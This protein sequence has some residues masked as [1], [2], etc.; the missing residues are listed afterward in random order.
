M[1]LLQA[2]HVVLDLCCGTCSWSLPWLARGFHVVAFDLYRHAMVPAAVEFRQQ[3]IALVD[4][5]EFAGR[6]RIVLASPPCDEYAR[7]AMPWTR[8]RNP[9]EPSTQLWEHC[10]RIASEAEAPLLLENV[11]T[12]QKWHGP[13]RWHHGP[14]YLWGDAVPAVMPHFQREF[15]KKKESYGSKRKDLR[16]AIPPELADHIARVYA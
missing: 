6:T 5:R 11:Q 4:G 12:A 9:P 3:D 13:A 7:W 1:N 2:E 15:F 14:F 10:E 16:A 8:A